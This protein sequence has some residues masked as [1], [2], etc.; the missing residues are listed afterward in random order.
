LH[1]IVRAKASTL[2]LRNLLGVEVER[3]KEKERERRAEKE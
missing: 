2:K 1:E 3:E